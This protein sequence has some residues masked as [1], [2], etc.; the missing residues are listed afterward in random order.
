MILSEKAVTELK[1]VLEKEIGIE[2]VL[3][4]SE[5]EINRLGVFLLST[6]AESLK[7]RKKIYN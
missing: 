5:N 6:F 1:K 2:S 4:L 3:M 7:I